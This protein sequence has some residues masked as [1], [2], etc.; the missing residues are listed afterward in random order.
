MVI[1][2]FVPDGAIDPVYFEDTYYLGAGKNG[3]RGYRVLAEALEK[4]K[5]IAVG[6]FTWRGKTTPIAIR[7][8]H[9]RLLLQRLYFAGEVHNSA[10]IDRGAVAQHLKSAKQSVLN[11]HENRPMQILGLTNDLEHGRCTRRLNSGLGLRRVLIRAGVRHAACRPE[12]QLTTRLVAR[13]IG[14]CG[15]GDSLEL[16]VC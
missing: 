11:P 9:D 13:P 6:T 7:R 5:R 4:T 12:R 14:T 2:S 3:E 16:V 10:E 8:H 15:A 1:D